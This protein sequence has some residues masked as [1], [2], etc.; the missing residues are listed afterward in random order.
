MRP[1]TKYTKG[2]PFKKNSGGAV[3]VVGRLSRIDLTDG[4]VEGGELTDVS[5]A[6][7]WYINATTRV[8]LNYIFASPK[9]QGSA[10]IFL[11]RVQY[12]PW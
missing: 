10:N 12:N 7:S 1:L 11:L 8:E 9:N 5:G 3:E 6:L 4:L 2:N